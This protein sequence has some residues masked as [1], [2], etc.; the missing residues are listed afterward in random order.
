MSLAPLLADAR[1][2]GY[3]VG[4]FSCLNLE[5]AAGIVAAAQDLRAPAVIAF[6]ARHAAWV[7]L[8]AL[9][10]AVRSLAARADVPLAL[11]LDHAKETAVVETAM[12]AGF[13]S[14]MFDGSGLPYA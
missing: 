8:P 10:A 12:E 2:Q 4:A 7:N 5:T 13:T 14:V 1:R 6:T 9:A 11:H 3:A